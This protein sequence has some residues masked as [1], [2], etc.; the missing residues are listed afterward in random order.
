MASPHRHGRERRTYPVVV[1]SGSYREMGEQIG[2][3]AADSIRAL[4]AMYA[5]D[6][7]KPN[8]ARVSVD[9]A[10]AQAKAECPHLLEEVEGMALGAGVSVQ[11]L[12]RL[13][14][15]GAVMPWQGAEPEPKAETGGRTS[16]ATVVEA[17]NAGQPSVRALLGQNWDN[18]PRVD[19]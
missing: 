6:D 19:P 7:A 17:E 14:G 5:E 2:R 12:F 8:A 11:S 10:L 13:N 1:A 18:E 3:A 4:C 16:L 9:A 15:G